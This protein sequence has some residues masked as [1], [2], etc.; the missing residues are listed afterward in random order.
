MYSKQIRKITSAGKK[1]QIKQY[2]PINAEKATPM[3]K[4]SSLRA[5]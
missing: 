4:P 5:Y 1:M 2:L 3:T